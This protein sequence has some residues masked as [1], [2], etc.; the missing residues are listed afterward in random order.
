MDNPFDKIVDYLFVGNAKSLELEKFD[1][2]VN[3]TKNIYFPTHFDGKCIRISV[4]DSPDECNTLLYEIH[5]TLVLENMNNYI[6]N[7]RSVLVHCSM[8]IQRSCSLVAC[9]LIKYYG[10]T[11][12][13]AIEYIRAKRPIAFFGNIHFLQTIEDFHHNLR[14]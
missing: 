7:K 6:R 3:C 11:P 9:Y 4:N 5:N 12:T 1:M 13:E 14:E 2:I 10:W 8:G